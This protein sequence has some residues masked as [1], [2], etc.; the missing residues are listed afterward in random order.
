MKQGESK[1]FV[2]GTGAAVIR[3]W[4]GNG[5]RQPSIAVVVPPTAEEGVLYPAEH[6]TLGYP[7]MRQLYEA[8]RWYYEDDDAAHE[9]EK[10]SK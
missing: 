8:L 10:A 5:N 1:A 2:I 4:G 7:Q 9:A 6:L 3:E